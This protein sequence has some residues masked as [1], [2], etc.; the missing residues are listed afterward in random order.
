MGVFLQQRPRYHLPMLRL[1]LA[2]LHLVAL[3]LG[4]MAVVMRGS[5]LKD[6]YSPTSL[7][8]ALLMDNIWG[9]AAALWIITGLWRFFGGTEKPTAYYLSNHLFLAKMA[10]FALIFALEISPMVTLMRTRLAM[11]RGMDPASVIAPAAR[12]IAVAGH[13]Q[14][15]LALIMIFLAVA[16]ARGYGAA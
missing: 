3:S 9:I 13:V 7:K 14:A 12:R 15:T 6:P 1:S 4:L 11:R 2:G 8:R 16:M 10:C 5:A